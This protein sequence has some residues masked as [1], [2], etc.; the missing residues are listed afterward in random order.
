VVYTFKSG[1]AETFRNGRVFIVGDAA[2]LM[3]PFAGQGMASGLR[4]VLNLT[5]KLD[6]ALKGRAADSLLETYTPE[7]TNHVSEMINFSMELGRIICITDPEAARQRDEAMKAAGRRR[8]Q[9][10]SPA[11][12][13]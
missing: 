7:R 11:T 10:S 9:A 13:G 6:L 1:W 8:T 12:P 5:W 3:P 2:H 4:D